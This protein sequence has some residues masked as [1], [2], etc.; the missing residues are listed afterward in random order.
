MSNILEGAVLLPTGVQRGGASIYRL[1][2]NGLTNEYFIVSGEGTRHLMASPE[3]V[4][5]ES[6]LAMTPST[7]AAL[8]YFVRDG[9]PD[10]VEILTIL[11]GGLNYPLEESCYRSGIRVG[12][13]NFVSCERIIE[14]GIIT[15]LEIKYEKL[16]I[17]KDA[18]LM[19][20]DIIASGDTLQLCLTRVFDRIRRR[21]GSVRK[22]IFFTI[23]GTK[24]IT[25]MEAMTEAVRKFWPDFEGF[26]CIFYEGIFTVY[27]DKGVTGVNIP[28]IDFGWRGG[29]VAP[30]FR[31]N[32]LSFYKYSLLEKC[33]IYDGGARRYEIPAHCDEVIEYWEDLLEASGRSDFDEFIREKIGYRGE[34]SYESWLELNHYTALGDLRKL[35]ELEQ[36]YIRMLRTESLEDICRARLREFRTAMQNYINK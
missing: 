18:I 28:D 2:K 12:N 6:Y 34:I 35:Y 20:G 11:R 31:H 5:Y 1:R 13:M 7:S 15:G 36:R 22:V 23:G 17:A 32:A 30:E 24:A 25:R 10:N 19:I 16:H 33:I 8:D 14:D 21:G 9:K 4:G 27:E 26:S 29:I 3:V